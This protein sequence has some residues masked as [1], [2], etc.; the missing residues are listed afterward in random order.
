MTFT[1]TSGD[2]ADQIYEKLITKDYFKDLA[3]AGISYLHINVPLEKLD[4][5]LHAV[6]AMDRRDFKEGKRY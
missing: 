5:L 6:E 2:I 4:E 3:L 1:Y